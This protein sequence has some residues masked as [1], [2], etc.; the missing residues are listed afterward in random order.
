M[1]DNPTAVCPDCDD[2]KVDVEIPG[3][4]YDHAYGNYLP[5][6]ETEPCDTCTG[7]G[8]VWLEFTQENEEGQ[9]EYA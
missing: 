6:W 8:R 9:H 5:K 4:Y 1:N 3:G 2:G 7:T